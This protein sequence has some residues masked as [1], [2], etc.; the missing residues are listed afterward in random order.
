M[1]K[2]FIFFIF[3]FRQSTAQL[4]QTQEGLLKNIVSF[5]KTSAVTGREEEARRFINQLFE[6]G[7]CRQDKLGNLIITIGDG[8]P[9]RLF[10]APMDEPGY[11]ISQIQEDG[12]LRITPV[13]YGQQGTMFH[14]F[15]EGNEVKINTENKI[16]IGVS[17]V[18]S[19]H[20]DGLR[21]IPE[22]NKN[23]FQWQEAFIDVGAS[24]ANAVAE[25][26]IH[27][28]DPLTLNKKPSVINGK[29]I[30][31]P[32]AASKAAVIAL[33]TVA[34]TLLQQKIAGTVVI[35]FTSLELI[36]GKG[37]EAIVNQYG[38]FEKVVR[39]NRFL[40]SDINNENEILVNKEI[41]GNSTVQKLVKPVI[42]FRHPST[43]A[44][45][46]KQAS[47]YDIGLPSNYTATP[48]E[49]ISVTSVE[50]LTQAW[51]KCVEDK[52]WNIHSLKPLQDVVKEESFSGFHKEAGLLSSLISKYG[53]NPDEKPVRDFI[54][55]QLPTWAR[56]VIDEKGNI[57]LT[58]GK[59]KQHIAFVAHMD[60][61][62]FLVDSI[63]N[64]GR[65]AVKDI[66]GF[67]NWIWEAHSALV[68]VADR[69]IAAVFEPRNNYMQ[70]TKRFNN[71]VPLLVYAGFHSKEEA[72]AA[73]VKPGLT[74]VTMPKKMIRLSET[75]ATA[76]GFDDRVGCAALLLALESVKPDD[77]PFTVTFVW[78][79]G[80]E[81]G[82]VGS[83]YAEKYLKDVSIGYPIDTYVSSDAPMES[84]IFGYCPLGKGA[85]IRVLESIN[86]ISRNNL[87]SLQTLA[88]KNAVKIQYGMTVGGTDGQGFLSNGIPSI[89]LSWPGRYSHSP[90][91]VMDFN[92]M[93]SLVQLIRAIMFDRS[94]KHE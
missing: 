62:G 57:V 76:R 54:L 83:T 17:T 55:T 53:V 7:I 50:Q 6:E 68:H 60:E 90:V 46:W 31:A 11:V 43:N 28:L 22:K 8:F 20:Y 25:K 86:F 89:P 12:Y 52:Q 65:L 74:S 56:P 9:K 69:D 92:D 61:V 82:L 73:G 66:G 94:A 32:S 58:F 3:C 19:S 2:V 87:K 93:K 21:A 10:V 41:P 4:S 35:A 42:A 84:K 72:I 26:G 37:M 18:P 91:E 23:V 80:E 44:S 40:N 81:I 27:L 39:F 79:I 24:S 49:M 15:L 77:L 85:V 71:G 88:A 75:K 51:L 14:Q 47:V 48:V 78:S 16:Q 59:G 38:P 64:D 36:N 45:E 13:G 5:S 30:A 33:A 70:A 1:K 34:H 67:F 63:L 29:Y